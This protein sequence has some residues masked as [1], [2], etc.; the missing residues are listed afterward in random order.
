VVRVAIYCRISKDDEGDALGVKRQQ[1]EALTFCAEHGYEEPTFFEDNDV[2]ASR[3]SR[4]RRP[5]FDRMLDAARAGELDVIVLYDLDRLT[6]VP[7]VGEDI[8]DLASGGLTIIDGNGVHDLTTGD[9]RHRFRGAINNAALESDKIS[10]RMKGKKEELAERGVPAGGGRAF[11]YE[12]DGVTVRE[13]EAVVYRQAARD[14]LAGKSTTSV[15]K[16]WNRQGLRT[17]KRGG[18]WTQ[19][20]VR[21][22]L[23]SPRHAGLRAH[24]GEVVGRAAWAAIIDR[25]THEA[26][27]AVLANNGKANPR[28][29]SLLTGLVRCGNCGTPMGRDGRSWRCR[30]T[31]TYPQACGHVQMRALGVEA[32]VEEMVI[33][34]LGSPKLA[35]A[36]ASQGGGG[37]E[38]AADSAALELAAA[39]AKL[40]EL[41]DMLGA[42]ELSRAS[43]LR[44]RKQPEK[45]LDEAR[46]RLARKNGQ[47]SLDRFRGKQ[48]PADL[49][50]KLDTDEKRAVIAALLDRIVIHAARSRAPKL[51]LTR[52]EPVWRA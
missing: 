48:H 4:K 29:R 20:M 2:S 33:E 15:A 18:M 6:R 12:P 22:V 49:Y 43:F 5:E 42:G 47:H 38:P 44:A 30:A 11:C 8:I 13:S 52:V 50:R 51:D 36:V 32:V 40:T 45:K 1:K 26:L 21:M 34:L 39:E 17:P 19:T 10:K 37:H 25:A 35:K 23:T 46:A 27:A 16:E 14:V 24:K 9:G 7:R 28:R 3:Y 41:D 31:N